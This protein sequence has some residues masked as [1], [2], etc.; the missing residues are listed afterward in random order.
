MHLIDREHLE[1]DFVF[2]EP[3]VVSFALAFGVNSFIGKKM[4]NFFIEIDFLFWTFGI[5]VK[6]LRKQHK[7]EK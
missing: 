6:Q 1:V 2:N 5:E 3:S 7:E 4:D